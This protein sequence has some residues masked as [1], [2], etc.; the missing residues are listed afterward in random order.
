MTRYLTA[1]LLFF[2]SA[3][4]H[5]FEVQLDG[6]GTNATGILDLEIDNVLYNVAFMSV[7]GPHDAPIESDIFA[8]HAADVAGA[9]AAVVA[10]NAALDTSDAVTV[11]SGGSSYIVP[12]LFNDATCDT[13][14]GKR[15]TYPPVV[16]TEWEGPTQADIGHNTVV[17]FAR[18]T[19][20]ISTPVPPAVFLFSSGLALL[21][22][23]RRRGG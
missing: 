13:L 20:A 14:C 23:L 15:G 12:Y 9:A 3:V 10:I 7:P 5:A 8:F 17:N 1:G 4:S 18:F 19:P 16:G 11:V 22:W 6:T 21:G 2:L